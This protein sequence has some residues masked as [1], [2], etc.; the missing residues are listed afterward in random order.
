MLFR[1]K[2]TQNA[3]TAL[4][5]ATFNTINSNI[6]TNEE[7]AFRV[8]S[9]G[10]VNNNQYTEFV[11]D[12]S[13]FRTN[14]VAFTVVDNF[15]SANII[16]NLAVTGN[17]L[18]SNIYN[19]SNLTS[20][21]TSLFQN[22]NATSYSTDLPTAGFVNT[23]DVDYQIYDLTAINTLPTLINGNKIWVAKNFSG[24]WD[25]IRATTAGV[26]ATS[27]SYTLDQFAVFTFSGAQIGRAHV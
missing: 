26:S 20:T 14:P 22:R 19:A 16:V 5:S 9:Y 25:V 4:T 27:L 21:S 1:S 8:G 15:S 12:Q 11:L 3:I 2:G 13:I 23:A 6:S 24:N 17:T 10:T 18:T 7:W